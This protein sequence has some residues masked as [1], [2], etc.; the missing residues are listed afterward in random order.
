MKLI[1]KTYEELYKPEISPN[2]ISDHFKFTHYLLGDYWRMLMYE[3][4]TY[5]SS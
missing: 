1:E 5:G 3:Y 2:S 4:V